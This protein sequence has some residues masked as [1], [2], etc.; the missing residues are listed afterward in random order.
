MF[1]IVEVRLYSRVGLRV[2]SRVSGHLPGPLQWKSLSSRVQFW[3]VLV[4]ELTA[5]NMFV[6]GTHLPCQNT[7]PRHGTWKLIAVNSLFLYKEGIHRSGS[8]AVLAVLMKVVF[9]FTLFL[10]L[11]NVSLCLTMICIMT[12]G[13]FLLQ[14]ASCCHFEVQLRTTLPLFLFAFFFPLSSYMKALAPHTCLFSAAWA[15]VNEPDLNEAFKAFRTCYAA[16]A[17]CYSWGHFVL[18]HFEDFSFF[19]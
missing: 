16:K 13:Y 18:S 2:C 3:D 6:S 10:V 5:G 19:F 7:H 4:S 1:G 15:L 14:S 9:P 17:V 12:A 8:P 11:V